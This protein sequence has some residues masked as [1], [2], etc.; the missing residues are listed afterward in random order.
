MGIL[1]RHFFIYNCFDAHHSKKFP[2]CL[3]PHTLFAALL[4]PGCDNGTEDKNS[5]GNNTGGNNTGD[6]NTGDDNTGGD[7]KTPASATLTWSGD[8]TRVSDTTYR[9]NAIGSNTNTIER[10]DIQATGAGT[11]TIQITASINIYNYGFASKLDRGVGEGEYNDNNQMHVSGTQVE[12][13]TYNISSGAHWI[14]FMY[15]KYSDYISGNDSVTV[16]I[17]S[18][19][20]TASGA[21]GNSKLKALNQSSVTLSDV[22]WGSTAV[23]ASLTPSE[24]K[25]VDV[26]EGSGYLYFT[27]GSADGLKCRTQEVI[28]V[29]KDETKE[30]TLT[31][32]TLVVALDDTNNPQALGTIEARVTQL[33]LSNQS[34]IE[35]TDVIWN[36]VSFANNTVENSIK[37]ATT[38]T[39]TVSAGSGYIFFKRKSSPIIARTKDLLIIEEFESKTLTFTDATEIVEVNNPDNTG[40]LGALQSTVV[41][42]DDAEGEMQ[43]Y[44]EAASFV[45]YYAAGS[46]LRD[47]FS[48]HNNFNPPKNG[49]K[50]IAVGGTTTA[51]LHLQVSLNKAAKL[52]FWYANKQLYSSTGTTFSINGTTQRTWSTDVNWSKLE[53]DLPA[54]VNDLVWE[55]KDG[56]SSYPYYNRYYY[57][58][59]D[60][61]LIYYTEE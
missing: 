31:N 44:Y 51:K 36:N 27:K 32:N 7:N 16:E 21:A 14:Q 17:I 47:S 38:V 10:L 56:Y 45:G 58:T 48:S 37:I 2:F 4:L 28:A 39:N 53:F 20:F 15:Q 13:Y 33:T 30:F 3:T 59:L 34:F 42:W 25:T 5:G 9:S 40:T 22:K 49:D 6:D 11:I 8:W 18:N 23:S 35:I 55:K 24:S 41:F 60:D 1:S 50:S 57:L 52:S 29:T 43:S 19:S 12:T 46:D 54:G 26:T 61:I